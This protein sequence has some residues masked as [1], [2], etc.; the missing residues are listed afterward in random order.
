M[1]QQKQAEASERTTEKRRAA[2]TPERRAAQAER[3][4]RL[5]KEVVRH[6][7]GK[8]KSE[9]HV[10]RIRAAWTPEKRRAARERGVKQ[11]TPEA[12]RKASVTHCAM[13]A[14]REVA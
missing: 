2:W 3:A 5:P 12:R 10:A 7:L 6:W 1:T 8:G 9:A 11:W 14:R 13:W 4:K